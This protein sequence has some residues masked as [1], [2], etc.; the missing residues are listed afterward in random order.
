MFELEEKVLFKDFSDII[1]DAISNSE[2][3]MWMLQSLEL[4]ESR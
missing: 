3:K 1:S 4:V 2:A